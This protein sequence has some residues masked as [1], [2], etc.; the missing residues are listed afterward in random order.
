MIVSTGA[1]GSRAGNCRWS[2]PTLTMVMIIISMTLL[3]GCT[4]QPRQYPEQQTESQHPLPA[5]LA[6]KVV[7]VMDL[8]DMGARNAVLALVE[9]TDYECPYCRAHY[10]QVLPL[11][12]QEFID[13]GRLNYYILDYPLAGHQ[14]AELASLAASC[15]ADQQA[16]WRFHDALFESSNLAHEGE[17][18][19][20]AAKLQLDIGAFETCLE[21][22]RHG[23]FLDSQRATALGLG[24]EGTPTFLLGRL[25]N[26]RVVTNITVLPGMQTIAQF[27]QAIGRYQHVSNGRP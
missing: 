12:K 9:V 15:A 20:I 26:G 13:T 11:L 5:S 6:N 25:H 7:R 19:V 18:H 22:R 10:R 27:R 1:W 17:L 16:Y 2:M 14:V 23:E 4:S 24:I 3:A 21:H 8:P